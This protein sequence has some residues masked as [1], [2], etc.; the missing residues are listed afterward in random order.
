MKVKCWLF[1]EV[2]CKVGVDYINNTIIHYYYVSNN[3]TEI[4]VE[5]IGLS[6]YF[7]LLAL[8]NHFFAVLLFKRL[9]KKLV[10]FLKKYF[11]IDI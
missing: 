9:L 6:K 5:Y 3:I 10:F 8:L 11:A 1:H 2:N 4:N 7:Y